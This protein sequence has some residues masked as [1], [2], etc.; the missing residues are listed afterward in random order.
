[1]SAVADF[2]RANCSLHSFIKQTQKFILRTQY[3]PLMCPSLP[4]SKLPTGGEQ[5]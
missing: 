1:M 4:D 5:D 3:D 2:E